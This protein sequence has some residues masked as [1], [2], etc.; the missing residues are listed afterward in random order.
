MFSFAQGGIVRQKE[1]GSIASLFSSLSGEAAQVLPDRFAELKREIW[2]D[3][4]VQSWREV[5]SA[6]EKAVDEV[7]T[8]GGSVSLV[9]IFSVRCESGKYNLIVIIIDHPSDCL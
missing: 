3:G 5:L 7:A 1:E 2:K 8:K 6:L 9:F 4:L